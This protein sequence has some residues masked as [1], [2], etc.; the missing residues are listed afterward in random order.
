MAKDI[1]KDYLKDFIEYRNNY[2]NY[3]P[4]K[5]LMPRD[6]DYY[7]YKCRGNFF[8]G[9]SSR[10]DRLINKGLIKNKEVIKEGQNFIIYVQKMD[11]SKFVTKKDIDKVNNFLDFMIANLSN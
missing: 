3:L 7:K 11:F 4:T 9:V 2:L 5:K 8:I 6:I 1:R 10:I